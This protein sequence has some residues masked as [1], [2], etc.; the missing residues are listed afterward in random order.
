MKSM[1]MTKSRLLVSRP[2]VGGCGAFNMCRD[3]ILFLGVCGVRQI[4][5]SV[6]RLEY[7]NSCDYGAS[8]VLDHAGLQ[9]PGY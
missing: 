1:V 3:T 7:F 6:C 2:V 4:N 9:I 5:M 8:G